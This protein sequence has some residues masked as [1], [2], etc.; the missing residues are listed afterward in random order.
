MRP[1]V[2]PGTGASGSSS[3][4]SRAPRAAE[5][6]RASAEGGRGPALA[7]AAGVLR[8]VGGAVEGGQGVVPDQGGAGGVGRDAEGGEVGDGG[9]GEVG[10]GGTGEVFDDGDSESVLVQDVIVG[11]AGGPVGGEAFRFGDLLRTKHEKAG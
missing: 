5:A 3:A 4:A 7:Q 11:E 10:A 6:R 2:T 9:G 8:E 1:A